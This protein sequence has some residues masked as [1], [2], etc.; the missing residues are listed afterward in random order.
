M[1]SPRLISSQSLSLIHILIVGLVLV[2]LA[3]KTLAIAFLQPVGSVPLI[4]GVLHLT[5]RENTGACLLYTSR[6][7]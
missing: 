6:C 3:L 5:Y 4:E 2:D 1:L 7:V